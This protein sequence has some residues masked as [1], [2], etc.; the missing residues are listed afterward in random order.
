MILLLLVNLSFKPHNW[1]SIANDAAANEL[2]AINK[3]LVKLKNYKFNINYQSFKGHF[4][5]KVYDEQRGI[6]L[7][8]EE[9]IYSKVNGAL[10]IQ[11]KDYR[12]IV[13]S[14]K[15]QINVTD[16]IKGQAPTFNIAD[17]LEL[18]KACKAV[19]R[20]DKDGIIAF[21]FE[22]KA[23][24]GIVIQEIYFNKDFLDRT[25][26]YYANEHS[27]R[28]NDQTKTEIVYPRMEIK[29]SAF[30]KLEKVNKNVFMINDFVSINKNKLST[31]EKYK[32]YKLLDGRFKK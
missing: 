17:Y 4:E 13:D 24:R 8:N 26:I 5:T 15:K 22:L 19:K 1:Q 14:I 31:S 16:P 7:K 6:V 30:E 29:I 28:E 32:T 23:N 21:R 2:I 27:V 18:L 11:N 9:L 25:V 10:T 12:I 3:E 20:F